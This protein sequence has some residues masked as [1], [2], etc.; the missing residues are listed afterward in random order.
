M[1]EIEVGCDARSRPAHPATQQIAPSTITVPLSRSSHGSHRL[2]YSRRWSC[3]RPILQERL[4]PPA[5]VTAQERTLNRTSMQQA[6]RHLDAA[7]GRS[8]SVGARN[9][10]CAASSQWL[11]WCWSRAASANDATPPGSAR[12]SRSRVRA[13]PA[14][15]IRISRSAP[16]TPV[17]D[18]LVA[19]SGR[20]ST[21]ASLRL[22]AGVDVD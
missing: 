3:E 6:G 15:A 21:R 22:L 10:G 4:R 20:P 12:S 14:A 13:N 16:T 19:A 9:P 11:P 18:E 17:F 7:T 8:A 2:S 1:P 5:A